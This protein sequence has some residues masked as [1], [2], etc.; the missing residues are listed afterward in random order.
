[1]L[2][3]YGNRK[4]G[5]NVVPHRCNSLVNYTLTSSLETLN[6]E[7]LFLLSSSKGAPSSEQPAVSISNKPVSMMVCVYTQEHV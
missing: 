6:I 4:F 1:M 2:W 5:V 7:F 3:V